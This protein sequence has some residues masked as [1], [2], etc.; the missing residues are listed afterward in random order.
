M[1]SISSEKDVTQRKTKIT[2][3]TEIQTNR[4]INAFNV[5]LLLKNIETMVYFFAAR[6]GTLSTFVLQKCQLPKYF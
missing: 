2:H 3:I 1:K 4:Q 6:N 5:T